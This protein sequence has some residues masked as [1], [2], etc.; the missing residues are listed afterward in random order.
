MSGL[1]LLSLINRAGS[2]LFHALVLQSADLINGAAEHSAKF[3]CV[4][5]IAVLSDQIHH[6]DCH[7]YRNAELH[8]LSRKVQVA[9]DICTVNNVQNR[10]RPLGHKIRSRYNF[11]KRVR[12]QRINT[13]KV[14]DYDIFI[15]LQF[16]FLFLDS[17]A[18][19]VADVLIGTRKSI[20]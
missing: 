17:D 13:R 18:R 16:S 4:D 10:V 11:L 15:V 7:D 20:K 1:A 6:I 8:E 2:N 14:L 3:R 12:R 9:F 19:P 5:L